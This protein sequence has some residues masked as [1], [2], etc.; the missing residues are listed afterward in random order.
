[1]LA[2][3]LDQYFAGPT[4]EERGSGLELT[5]NGFVGYRK[6]EF[7]NGVVSVYLAGNCAPSGIGYSL[8]RP[9]I[10]TLR[11]FPGVLYVKLYDAYDHTGNA[12]SAADSWPTCLDVIFTLTPTASATFTPTLTPSITPTATPIPTSTPRPTSTATPLPTH[13]PVPS[14]TPSPLPTRTPLP[15]ATRT[16]VPSATSTPL[17]TATTTRTPVPTATFTVTPSRTPTSSPTATLTWTPSP[18]LTPKPT[19]TPLPSPTSSPSRTPRPSATASPS[20]TPSI[21]FTPG[22]TWTPRPTLTLTPINAPTRTAAAAPQATAKIPTGPTPT[23]DSACDHAEFLGDVT[24]VDNATLRP[25]EAFR[26]TWRIQNAGNCSWTS[27]YRL[28]FVRGDHMGGPDAVPM[29]ALVAPGQSADVSVD[30]VAPT[31]QGQYGGFWQLQTPG[32]TNFGLGPTGSGNL[33][34]QISVAGEP[35]A[36]STS[37]RG[38]VVPSITPTGWA[39][40]TLTAFVS[41]Q[42]A[43]AAPTVTT[44]ATVQPVE[45]ADLATNACT[46]Q[47]QANDGILGCPGA[48]GDPR[49]LV[50]PLTQANIEDG[51]RLSAPTL[52]TIP[53][54]G[55]DGYIL[56]LY[57]QYQVKRGDHFQVGAGCEAA[58]QGCSVLFRVSY[59]DT[60]GAAHDLW[61]IG[62]FLDG[63][64]TDLDLD[65]GDLAGQ[66]IRLVLSVSNLGNADGDRALWI[67][68]RIVNISTSAQAGPS[69]VAPTTTARPTVTLA[70]S[71]TPRILPPTPTTVP[72]TATPTAKPPIPQFYDMLVEFFRQLF[73]QR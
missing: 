16:P 11:Q 62:E 13:T 24:I 46:A 5:R 15:T 6:V 28:V 39:E 69:A 35:V 26:K 61:T 57:P 59:L 52:L 22:P 8:A 14:N 49:G 27:A 7:A 18:S 58:A 36:T 68:P 64:H 73:G 51:T 37:T 25:G 33:W 40:A 54:A 10:A 2:A 66:Q 50:A 47:W 29:P 71:P 45:V 70:P 3:A 67:E 63:H 60:S 48:E 9:L 43:A 55:Q 32:G 42:T 20:L 53:S 44:A 21:T 65:L 19:R 72:V 4:I 56:G 23:L 1:M 31:S 12:L 17:P 30:L 41:T 34:V 38:V